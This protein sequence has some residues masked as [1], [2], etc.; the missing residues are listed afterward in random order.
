[1]MFNPTEEELILRKKIEKC[2]DEKELKRLKKELYD[3]EEKMFEKK[4][5]SPFC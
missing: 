2:D 4:R 1:M 3:L 5:N